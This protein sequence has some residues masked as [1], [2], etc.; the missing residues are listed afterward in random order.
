[1]AHWWDEWLLNP[2]CL[3]PN[4]EQGDRIRNGGTVPISPL[5]SRMSPTLQSGEE[6]QNLPTGGQR[7]CLGGSQFFRAGGKILECPIGGL[8]GYISFGVPGGP[9]LFRAGRE[10]TNAH[11]WAE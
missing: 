9:Q 8:T 4:A 7:G 10:I 1:M 5:P 6:N 2:C 3:V 11:W